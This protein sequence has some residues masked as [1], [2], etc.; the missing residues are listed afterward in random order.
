[1]IPSNDSDTKLRCPPLKGTPP[2]LRQLLRA[3]LLISSVA[4]VACEDDSR[5]YPYSIHFPDITCAEAAEIDDVDE[6]MECVSDSAAI[7]ATCGNMDD[8]SA[9]MTYYMATC[10]FCDDPQLGSSCSW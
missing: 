10:D 9:L 8:G 4:F 2:R 5:E 1:M 6:G 3:G 7:V